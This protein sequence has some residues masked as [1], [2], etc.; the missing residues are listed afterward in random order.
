MP[1]YKN[2]SNQGSPLKAIMQRFNPQSLGN[3]SPKSIK[4]VTDPY[5]IIERGFGKN[6]WHADFIKPPQ[7]NAMTY[8]Q[9]H[10]YKGKRNEYLMFVEYDGKKE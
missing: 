2:T 8:C 7:T 1:V 10:K 4:V 5:D 3:S 6:R 9:I